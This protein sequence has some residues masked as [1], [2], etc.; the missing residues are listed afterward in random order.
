MKLPQIL[1][2]FKSKAQSIIQRSERGIVAII[3]KDDT[4]GA[5][6]FKIYTVSY[7]HLTLPTN[8]EV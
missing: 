8:R 2:E 6:P 7:T 1:I 4:E 5:E 3:L